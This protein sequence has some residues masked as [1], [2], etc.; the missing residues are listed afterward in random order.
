MFNR[1]ERLAEIEGAVLA[2]ASVYENRRDVSENYGIFRYKILD[3]SDVYC[4]RYVRAI[5]RESRDESSKLEIAS[6]RKF[7]SPA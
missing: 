2:Y 5:E 6:H 7:I 4:I 1:S 3:L